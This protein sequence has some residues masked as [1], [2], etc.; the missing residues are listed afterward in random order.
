MA[1]ATH[2]QTADHHD[3]LGQA[4]ADSAA[5]LLGTGGD[6]AALYAAMAE[7]GWQAVA[8]SEDK[9]GLGLGLADLAA[10]ARA[11]GEARS[12]VPVMA[13]AGIAAPLLAAAEGSLADDLLGAT[14]SGEAV[15]ALAHQGAG[16][17]FARGHRI[18]ALAPAPGGHRL[19]G[20]FV[21]VEAAGL[22]SHLLVPARDPHGVTALVVLAVGDAGVER[23]L[24][25]ALDGRM[26]M[27]VAIDAAITAEQIL[28][29]PSADAALD[30]ALDRGALLV[31]A[32]AVGSMRVL[33]ADTL[34]YLK[35]RQQFGQPIG[36]F[37][38][39]QHRAVDMTIAL[40]E[41][42]AVVDAAAAAPT[43]D[44]ARA[45]AVAKVIGCR[46]A[47]LI[48]REAVQMHGGIGIT[49]DL[50]V[51]HHFRALVAAESRYGD[52]DAYRARFAALDAHPAPE[53]CP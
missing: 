21:A 18:G 50:R 1:T 46:S 40:E 16:A 23:R 17:G 28:A 14:L 25:R 12:T 34:G 39:L 47:R 11:L 8:I 52:D 7:A 9:G 51:S 6:E 4:L 2:A 27:D 22:A 53:Q 10:L 35:T 19:T 3:D 30:A 20:A 26:L 48:A 32:E 36:R 15:P 38:A 5:R 45:V 37:Q 31:M 29:L 49:E 44:F 24:Y 42:E 43:A 33:L 41:A 13:V